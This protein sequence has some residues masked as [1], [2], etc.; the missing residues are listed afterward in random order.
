MKSSLKGLIKKEN[1][2]PKTTVPGRPDGQE[3]KAKTNEKDRTIAGARIIL[4]QSEFI[5]DM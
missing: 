5:P 2:I 1:R 4:V 3:S